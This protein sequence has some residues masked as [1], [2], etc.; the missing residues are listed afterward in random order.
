MF[1]V[2]GASISLHETLMIV[3]ATTLVSL[4]KTLMFGTAITLAFPYEALM[5]I[6]NKALASPHETSMF[7]LVFLYESSMHV[8][9]FWHVSLQPTG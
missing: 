7:A 2:D 5:S 3:T 6:V 8:V 4:H 9:S 1:I